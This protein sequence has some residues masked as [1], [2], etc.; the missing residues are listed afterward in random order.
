MI[1]VEVHAAHC[2]IA[3]KRNNTM[4]S[5]FLVDT[6][7]KVLGGKTGPVRGEVARV[8]IKGVTAVVVK[9]S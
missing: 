8:R 9:V 5:R 4:D 3:N 7:S 2:R 6:S 1:N